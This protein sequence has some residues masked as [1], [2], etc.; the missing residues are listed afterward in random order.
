MK[1]VE[2]EG[3]EEEELG[4]ESPPSVTHGYGALSPLLMSDVEPDS[5]D[6]SQEKSAEVIPVKVRI[7]GSSTA[8]VV[9]P[10]SYTHL[11][12]PTIYSV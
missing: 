10:V 1:G 12:L 9:T 6:T 3:D 7:V 5:P 2:E 8:T 4:V 11:T